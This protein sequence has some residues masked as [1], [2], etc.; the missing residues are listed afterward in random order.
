MGED[1]DPLTTEEPMPPEISHRGILLKMAGVVVVG[2][3][4][5]FVGVGHV[6]RR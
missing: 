1:F 6:I 4:A 3:L 5:G 2:S